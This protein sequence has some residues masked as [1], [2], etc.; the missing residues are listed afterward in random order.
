MDSLKNIAEALLAAL[1]QEVATPS[2]GEVLTEI[3]KRANPNTPEFYIFKHFKWHGTA[4][5]NTVFK[6]NFWQAVLDFSEFLTK[7]NPLGGWDYILNRYEVITEDSEW[8]S[9]D[10]EESLLD[11]L[12]VEMQKFEMDN[13]TMWAT[14]LVLY[15]KA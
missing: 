1:P 8:Y 14:K 4:S 2:Y 7:K 9:I 6:G 10:S 13:D 3:K 15:Q 12:L 5:L 11:Q